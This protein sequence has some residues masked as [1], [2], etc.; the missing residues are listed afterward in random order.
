[1]MRAIADAHAGLGKVELE[2][3]DILGRGRVGRPFEKCCETLATA[4]V[5]CLRGRTGLRAVM[6]SIIRWR[7]GLM[8]SVLIGNSC[9]R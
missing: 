6:S 8:V 4:D 2:A 7:S 9:L 3:A 5:A 1:M